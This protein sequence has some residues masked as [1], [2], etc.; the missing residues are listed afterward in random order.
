MW[1]VNFALALQTCTGKLHGSMSSIQHI[2]KESHGD[3]YTHYAKPAQKL[4]RCAAHP[5]NTCLPTLCNVPFCHMF[6]PRRHVMN[7]IHSI[8]RFFHFTYRHVS[9]VSRH[10]YSRVVYVTLHKRVVSKYVYIY[11]HTVTMRLHTMF[12]DNC[13]IRTIW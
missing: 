11:I 9:L 4:L 12:N 2:R 13:D 3:T 1:L 8:R 6:S 5:Q 10:R 7:A